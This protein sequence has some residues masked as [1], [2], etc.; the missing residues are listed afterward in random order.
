MNQLEKPIALHEIF[1]SSAA[2]IENPKKG[3]IL[4]CEGESAN[5]VFY[6]ESGM[7][8]VFS[9][10]GYEEIISDIPP[11]GA[12]FG[13]EAFNSKKTYS[14]YAEVH[15]NEAEIGF[16]FTK[17]LK[18]ILDKVPSASIPILAALSEANIRITDHLKRLAFGTIDERLASAI[19]DFARDDAEGDLIQVTSTRLAKRAGMHEV[20]AKR[21][22]GDLRKKDVIRSTYKG[23]IINSKEALEEIARIKEE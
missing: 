3:D 22:I 16:L 9:S 13:L 6:L 17:R 19:L 7:V 2:T 8:V 15:S 12:L 14:T 20:T 10:E 11:K 4:F 23:I 5:R 21:K 1:M 18:M